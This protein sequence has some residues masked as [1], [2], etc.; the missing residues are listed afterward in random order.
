MEPGFPRFIVRVTGVPFGPRIRPDIWSVVI[1]VTSRP[2]TASITSFARS[3]A[4]S[5]GV[6]GIGLV[7]VGRPFC[8]SKYIPTPSKLP[9]IWLCT[10]LF[11]SGVRKVEK[12]SPRDCIMPLVA[13]I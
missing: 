9:A 5:A 4:C 8:I 6:L 2:F 11:S 1:L 10:A 3:P 7:M 13:A 12:L